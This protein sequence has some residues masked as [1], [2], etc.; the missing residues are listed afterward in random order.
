M[1]QFPATKDKNV[2]AQI[3]EDAFAFQHHGETIIQTVDLITPVVDDPYEFGSIAVANALS[4]I[5]AKGG[6]PK[7]ALNII[8]FPVSSLPLSHLEKMLAGG[9]DKASEAGVAIVGGHTIDDSPKYGVAVTGFIPEGGKFISKSE[10]KLGDLIF[11]TKPLGS[12][13]YTTGIDQQV[14]SD[15]QINEVTLLMNQLNQG[16]AN[17]FR[18]VQLNACTDVTGFGLLGH[19]KE[20]AESSKIIIELDIS[21]IPY[22]QDVFQLISQGAVTE[23]ILKNKQSFHQYIKHSTPLTREEEYLL[24]DPQTSGGL[25]VFVPSEE[26]EN[27]IKEFEKNNVTASLIGMVLKTGDPCIITK[28]NIE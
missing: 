16:A 20:V 6:I 10:A 14:V 17:A 25:L 4:D 26:K 11:L 27:I 21:R 7:Y 18:Q 12:G 15:K 24:Y 23:G 8:E 13:I 1:R 2:I 5:Y 22:L 3:G 28:N 9:R 19:L